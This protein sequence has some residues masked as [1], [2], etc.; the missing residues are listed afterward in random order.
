MERLRPY[1][2]LDNPGWFRKILPE[3]SV[4]QEG[5]SDP[6]FHNGHKSVGLYGCIVR[7][8]PEL[9][10]D[11]LSDCAVVQASLLSPRMSYGRTVM[12]GRYFDA[13]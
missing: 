4:F 9:S 11:P 5:Y 8:E 3:Q 2:L 13:P 6:H 7:P 12:S 1:V 10:H